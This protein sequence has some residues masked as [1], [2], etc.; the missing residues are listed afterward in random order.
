[1]TIIIMMI[2]HCDFCIGPGNRRKSI[3]GLD[4]W[5]A[6]EKRREEKKSVCTGPKQDKTN[7]FSSP[8]VRDQHH[9]SH[10][11][12]RSPS[13]RSPSFYFASFLTASLRI[14]QSVCASHLS[15]MRTKRSQDTSFCLSLS[16][17]LLPFFLFLVSFS[18][19]PSILHPYV[20]DRKRGLCV[21][22]TNLVLKKWSKSGGDVTPTRGKGIHARKKRKE[23]KEMK[24][25]TNLFLSLSWRKAA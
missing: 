9:R 18:P 24:R 5:L 20:A 22:E 11:G 2:A 13:V 8:P 25:K 16:L 15:M 12:L 4:Q 3:S 19:F 17:S 21:R 7:V 23:M 14:Q 10:V 6:Q 1:M